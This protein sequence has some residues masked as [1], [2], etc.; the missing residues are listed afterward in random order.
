MASW[1]F[2]CCT[3]SRTVC[4][5]RAHRPC[6]ADRA[7][8][9]PA[10]SFNVSAVSADS[11]RIIN[12]NWVP[13]ACSAVCI[14]STVVCSCA[15]VSSCCWSEAASLTAVMEPSANRTQGQR[16][17]LLLYLFDG[18]LD[19][20]SGDTG[21]VGKTDIFRAARTG[22]RLYQRIVCGA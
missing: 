20:G 12:G 8:R 19:I 18:T 15:M 17:Q 1:H 6:S 14:C 22:K 9:M 10:H 21:G 3:A 4:R 11:A 5:D 13:E 16:G 7:Q 2:F